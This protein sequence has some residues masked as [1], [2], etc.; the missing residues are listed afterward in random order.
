M[1]L[2]YTMVLEAIAERIE[3]SSLSAPTKFKGSRMLTDAEKEAAVEWYASCDDEYLEH[4][5]ERLQYA[6]QE[7]KKEKNNSC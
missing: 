3:S 7:R 4:L 5:L 1:E 6:I 2:G